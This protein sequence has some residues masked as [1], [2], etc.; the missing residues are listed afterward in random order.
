MEVGGITIDKEAVY[1]WKNKLRVRFIERR[2]GDLFIFRTLAP[3]NGR[4]RF[5]YVPELY[6]NK[7]I[8]ITTDRI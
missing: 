4:H 6:L 5:V 3:L 2:A 7:D 1:V 8:F